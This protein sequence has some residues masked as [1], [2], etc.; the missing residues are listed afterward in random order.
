[1]AYFPPNDVTNSGNI[2]TQ[3]LNPNSGTATANSTIG[4]SGLNGR[5]SVTIHIT[6][7]TLNQALTPQFTIDGSNWLTATVINIITKEQLNSIPAAQ[8]GSYELNGAGFIGFRISENS[9][10]T[11]SA[12]VFVRGSYATAVISVD[13]LQDFFVTGASAQTATVNNILTSTSGTNGSDLLPY[14]SACVQVVSTGTGG[15]YI[16]EGSND[17]VNNFQTIPVWN[18]ATA[19][20]TPITA[21][22]TAT[23][24]QIGYIFPRTF[25][26][27]RLRIATTITGGSIQA[28]STFS[29][30]PFS[31]NYYQVA[32]AT[33]ANLNATVTATNLSTNV[34][35]IGGTNTVNGGVAGTLAVGGNVAHSAASTA[36]PLQAGGRV[37]PTTIAT[38]D[39][40][41]VAGDVSYLPISTGLQAITKNFSSAELDYSIQFDSVGTTTTV[42]Q[43]VPASGTASVR[44]YITSFVVSNDTLGAAGTAWVLD[45]ALTVSSIAITT[46]LTTTST[47]HDLKVGDAVVFTALAAGT[48]VSTN[49][50]YYVTSVGSTTTFNFSATVGGSNVVPSV[51]YTGTTMYRILHQFRFQTTAQQSVSFVLP[52]PYRGIANTACNFLIPTT[53]TSGSIYLTVT[54]YRGF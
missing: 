46:G 8:T 22:I 41:L 42:Q 48:G 23:S 34:A 27:V 38:T 24:S 1:M 43:L 25:R 32:N 52:N 17:P 28:V 19:T 7:N 13:N 4:I 20:G 51:A 18:Q 9:A 50:K 30:A 45:S 37:V 16:F 47:A 31:P 26:Y 14:R 11:G 44:N 40:S 12:T 36:N 39:A 29:Q 21:A 35:Q 54:G 5:D 3:N 10:V 15:T 6:A 33:A 2:T 49:T 53:L